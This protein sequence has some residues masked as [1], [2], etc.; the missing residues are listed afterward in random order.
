MKKIVGII[1]MLIMVWTLAPLAQGFAAEDISSLGGSTGYA[2]SYEATQVEIDA[3][4][5]E[6]RRAEK[7]MA[8]ARAAAK[9]E[10]EITN[11]AL[12][13][14][15]RLGAEN[16]K[17][18]KDNKKAVGEVDRKIDIVDG[19]VNS[20]GW[21]TLYGMIILLVAG[22]IIAA[23]CMVWSG[24][25]NRNHLGQSLEPVTTGLA[26]NRVA[27]DNL[28]TR[29]AAVETQLSDMPERV[30]KAVR[31]AEPVT[32]DIS[33]VCGKNLK[34]T[35]PITADGERYVMLHVPE[36]VT[37]PVTDPSKIIRSESSGNVGKLKDSVRRS[38]KEY[39]ALKANPP[40][41]PTE[42]EKQVILLFESRKPSEL[43]IS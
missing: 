19:A 1:I 21:L 30:A 8:A 24:R 3:L 7:Q 13:T 33:D 10:A 27:V 34:Y 25:R 12:V 5:K 26:E 2:P 35:P 18:A 31:K 23:V 37:R 22:I 38:Y 15:V 17:D 11:R 42:R 43:E 32:L 20:L 28:S 9:R 4:T 39:C 41:A 6:V 29:V 14:V 36:S 40:T 16:F